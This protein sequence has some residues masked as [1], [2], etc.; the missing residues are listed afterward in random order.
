MNRLLCINPAWAFCSLRKW[1]GNTIIQNL[2]CAF[3]VH[4]GYSH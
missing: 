3:L 2:I 4:I 1:A